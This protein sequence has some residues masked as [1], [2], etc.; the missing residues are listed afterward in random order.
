MEI[1]FLGPDL[2]YKLARGAGEEVKKIT[3]WLDK[4]RENEDIQVRVLAGTYLFL[5][6]LV[7]ERI[8]DEDDPS[9]RLRFSDVKDNMLGDFDEFLRNGWVVELDHPIEKAT[10]EKF[11][12][13]DVVRDHHELGRFWDARFRLIAGAASVVQQNPRSQAIILDTTE[14]HQLFGEYA[15]TFGVQ[16]MDVGMT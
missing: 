6:D 7:N 9:V 8:F 13:Y 11:R 12:L 10:I 2:L 16:F 4:V 3:K 5:V 15:S 1:Y 14:S